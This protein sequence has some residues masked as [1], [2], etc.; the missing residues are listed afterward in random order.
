MRDDFDYK[1]IDDSSVIRTE[2]GFIQGD[3]RAIFIKVGLEGTIYG[4]ENK[5]LEIADRLNQLYGYTV[6][7]ASNPSEK[8]KSLSR[9]VEI[10]RDY[11]KRIGYEDA[12]YAYMGVSNGAYLG[13]V[14]GYKYEFSR[15][16]FI[17][18]PLMINY[19]KIKTG[20]SNLTSSKVL[21]VYSE[22]DPSIKYVEMLRGSIGPN[23]ELRIIPGADH[24]FKGK[25]EAFTELPI[26]FFK[27]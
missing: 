3:N 10:L 12:S 18:S 22:H 23:A 2:Y 20:L 11:L 24:Q 5:Y 27:R 19:H 7:V 26:N 14:E 17:N 15:Y 4:Y 8:N 6:M 25:L 1:Y 9:G 16:L 13:L 21:I